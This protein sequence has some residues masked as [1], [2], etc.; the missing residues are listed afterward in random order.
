MS[1]A[2]LERL[3][4]DLCV[5]IPFCPHEPSRRQRAFLALTERREVLYG[6]AAMG[7][8]TDA[9]LMAA[10]QYVHEPDY[11][12]IILRRTMT[13]LELD[14][15]ILFRAHQWLDGVPG[16]RYDGRNFR[17]TFPSGARLSFGYINEEP[18]RFRY[19]STEFQF[20]G[21]DELTTFTEPMYTYMFSRL[22][23]HKDSRVPLRM[24]GATNPGDVGHGW[25]MARFGLT[26]EG[27]QL[28][29]WTYNGQ[30]R[31]RADCAF[32]PAKVQDNPAADSEDYLASLARMSDTTSYDQLAL[33]IWI[34]DDGQRV[35]RHD[36]SHDVATLPAQDPNGRPLDPG[37][38]IR[39]FVADLG[40]SEVK[41]T[42]GF[43]AVAWHPHHPHTYVERAW[44]E[45]GII[46]ATLA[47]RFQ[48]E[49]GTYGDGLICII[50]EGALGHAYGNELRV[51]YG[52]PIIAA[53][54]SEKRSNRRLLNGSLEKGETHLIK[55]ECDAVASEWAS[56]VYA[57]NG[58]DE[59]AGLANHCA[60]AVLY[61]WRYSQAHRS[62]SV[63][64][65]PEFQSP[66]W[67][68][69]RAAEAERQDREPVDE[70]TAYERW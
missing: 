63:A 66:D 25:V 59:A 61:G 17:F 8:K 37:Q 50:D 30:P 35:Y 21:F 39:A 22:R 7:G 42:T 1:D 58:L 26:K 5:T 34:L 46:P 57:K 62:E 32:V 52:L 44:K 64:V 4:A 56:L 24:R 11:S 3:R 51:R 29:Q 40:A 65:E 67:W 49:I 15:S 14:G 38:W 13:D 48:R 28:D 70:S 2:D 20:I 53:E 43:A 10:L 47:E 33:G 12:A 16:I 9:L 23:R 27:K 45:A 31:T 18:D 60:D 41:P 55:G 68:A 36:P 6:G 54:K 19:K 69:A